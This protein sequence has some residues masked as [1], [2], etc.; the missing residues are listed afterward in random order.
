MRANFQSLA[1]KYSALNERDNKAFISFYEQN[2]DE[3]KNLRDFETD[4]ELYLAVVTNHTYG[5]SQLYENKNL[6]KAEQFLNLSRTLILEHKDKFGIELMEDI[7]YL[8]TLQHLLTT[9]L[10]ARNRNKALR[11]LE[12]L[13][14]IDEENR[15]YYELEEKEIRRIQKYKMLMALVYTGLGLLAISTAYRFV[16]NKLLWFIGRIGQVLGLCGLIGAYFFKDSV[17]STAPN[18]VYKSW[19]GAR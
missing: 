11:V 15:Q 16:T 9:H 8:Q 6:E 17:K 3:I 13:K 2:T 5:R 10:T 1:D 14:V 4:E 12:D 19:P 7:W 18:I